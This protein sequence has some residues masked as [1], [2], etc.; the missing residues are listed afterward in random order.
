M[1]RTAA[2]GAQTEAGHGDV[3][4]VVPSYNRMDRLPAVIEPVLR[5][6]ATREVV[7]VADGS[8]DGTVEWLDA[9]GR[10]DPRLRC[11]VTSNQGA[12]LA[13]QTGAEHACGEIVL[14]LDDDV[15]PSPGMV[16]GHGHRHGNAGG[17][18]VLGDM[19]IVS[20]QKGPDAWIVER[21]RKRYEEQRLLWQA[22]PD[23]I[24]ERLWAGN[25]SL[26]RASIQAMGG[27]D[28]GVRLNYHPDLAYGLRAQ[29]AGLRGIFA[30]EP[31][32]EHRYERDLAGLCRDSFNQGHDRAVLCGLYPER[33]G[34]VSGRGLVGRP[35]LTSR[36]Y[37]LAALGS[38]R[39]LTTG[40]LRRVVNWASAGGR[41][42]LLDLSRRHLIATET[43][44]GIRAAIRDGH[45]RPIG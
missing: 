41:L 1:P 27:L 7:V 3:S 18:I 15:I 24:L 36:M 6:S 21:Y 33:F 31:V 30:P 11:V 10:D 22:E 2:T 5:D 29:R 44:A 40:A 32:A 43:A 35:P 9:R 26:S 23:R 4:V 42:R 34:E 25:F 45:P 19:P 38:F 37:G 13:R 8:T 28:P 17:L 14:F 20:P 39:P 12:G 16:S